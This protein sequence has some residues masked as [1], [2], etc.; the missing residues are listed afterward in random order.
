MYTG[1][2]SLYKGMEVLVSQFVKVNLF[3]LSVFPAY[4]SIY[5]DS[6]VKIPD[7]YFGIMRILAQKLVMN[8][9]QFCPTTTV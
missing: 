6:E 8:S 7:T 4:C 5:S 9:L 1:S 2:T 3:Y